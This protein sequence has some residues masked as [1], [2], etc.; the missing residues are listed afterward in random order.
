MKKGWGGR[1]NIGSGWGAWGPAGFKE[2]TPQRWKPAK[3]SR[4][5][6]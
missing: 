4:K 6:V 2:K 5:K 3:N 1:K